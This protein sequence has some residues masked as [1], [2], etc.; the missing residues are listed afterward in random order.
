MRSTTGVRVWGLAWGFSWLGF[1]FMSCSI[2]AAREQAD[3]HSSLQGLS[4]GPRGAPLKGAPLEKDAAIVNV[5]GK[6]KNQEI[7]RHSFVAHESLLQE[8]T[9]EGAPL[10]ESMTRARGEEGAA[11]ATATAT[12][13]AAAAAAGAER[14]AAA[15]AAAEGG[16]EKG[17]LTVTGAASSWDPSIP[18]G[19]EQPLK[20]WTGS[21]TER[22]AEASKEIHE[23]TEGRESEELKAVAAA[24]SN[25]GVAG[26]HTLHHEDSAAEADTGLGAQALH[27]D[28]QEGISNSSRGSSSSGGSGIISSINSSDESRGAGYSPGFMGGGMMGPVALQT[29]NRPLSRPLFSFAQKPEV[30]E[31]IDDESIIPP[32][33]VGTG[34]SGGGDSGKETEKETEEKEPGK[35]VEGGTGTGTGTEIET[36]TEKEGE[37]ENAKEETDGETGGTGKVPDK[38]AAGEAGGGQTGGGVNPS[39]DKDS[40]GAC[41]EE[42][43]PVA[44]DSSFL[45]E[46]CVGPIYL[47]YQGENTT[48]FIER[49]LLISNKGSEVIRVTLSLGNATFT[50]DQQHTSSNQQDQHQQHQHQQQQQQQQQPQEKAEDLARDV[51]KFRRKYPKSHPEVLLFL[52]REGSSTTAGENTGVLQ[53]NEGA[54]AAA[55]VC[56]S[57]VAILG[58]LGHVERQEEDFSSGLSARH[59]A[60]IRGSVS[61]QMASAKLDAPKP[62]ASPLQTFRSHQEKLGKASAGVA[63]DSVYEEKLWGLFAAKC[64]DAFRL[65]EKGSRDV[66]VG[67]VDTGISTHSDLEDSIVITRGNLAAVDAPDDDPDADADVAA[68]AAAATPA[69]A[70]VAAAAVCAAHAVNDSSYSPLFPSAPSV[71]GGFVMDA[72]GHGTH[73]SGIIAA[74]DNGV[75]VCGCAPN[76]K[77]VQAKF[78]NPNGEGSV[79]SALKAIDFALSAGVQIINNSWGAPSESKALKRALQIA[80]TA[81]DG[82]GVLVVNSA[83]NEAMDI[84]KNSFFP[85]SIQLPNSITVAAM[86]PGGQLVSYSNYGVE[87]VHLAA[88]GENI[89]SDLPGNTY[90]YRSGSSSAAP[91]VAGKVAWGATV[92][93]EAAVQVARLGGMWAQLRC[94]DKEFYL[95][96]GEARAVTVYVRAYLPGNY[97]PASHKPSKTHQLQPPIAVFLLLFDLR[98]FSRRAQLHVSVFS[99]SNGNFVTG[100]G[101]RIR[102]SSNRFIPLETHKVNL[103]KAVEAEGA[104]SDL[105]QDANEDDSHLCNLQKR[106]LVITSAASLLSCT[107]TTQQRQLLMLLLLLLLL[108]LAVSGSS[109]P[110][111]VLGTDKALE[112]SEEDEEEGLLSEFGEAIVE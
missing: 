82:L 6:A 25:H 53:T 41:T 23:Q 51:A 33:P 78:T 3:P 98:F 18:A 94:S 29:A 88:P 2:S 32:V 48:K 90:G 66:L 104:F 12:S 103:Q 60:I 54:T 49:R 24:D 107:Y 112:A 4:G 36:E 86:T 57:V 108:L 27:G 89:Y 96:P 73:V 46:R 71:A 79:A 56:N 65:G 17:M 1:V 16:S 101:V 100:G 7:G 83:G 95:R 55:A 19:R 105:L 109:R 80:A 21:L 61:V 99:A 47:R 92:D 111:D 35:E 67:I 106:F 10:V 39:I 75:G 81:N 64:I 63:A 43:G 11:T 110:D 5:H 72:H 87:S 22:E 34:G 52:G 93:A 37:K 77:L 70:T 14:A 28:G 59:E 45:S 15:A 97:G 26:A 62:V 91:F 31:V 68:P 74:S 102:M 42:F 20:I 30:E 40:A 50:P 44:V 84:D 38:E 58:D 76:T 9:G 69:A 8:E 85:A 13:A